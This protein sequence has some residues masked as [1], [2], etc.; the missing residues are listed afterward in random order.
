MD[1]GDAHSRRTWA[2]NANGDTYGTIIKD[3]GATPDLLSAYATNGR[4]GSVD[5]KNFD[6]DGARSVPVY[7]SDGE[8]VI[9]EFVIDPGQAGY[10]APRPPTP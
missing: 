9:G 1:G 6:H 4:L 2:T 3:S 7:E 5:E 10:G 8:T